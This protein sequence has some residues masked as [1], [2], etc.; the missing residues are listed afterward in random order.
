MQ[1]LHLFNDDWKFHFGDI[2]TVRNRWAWAKSGSFNQGPESIAFDDLKWREVRL[3][4][5][6]VFETTPYAYSE[7]E[8]DEDN[9]IPEMEDVGNIHTTA[10]SFDKNVGWYRKHFFIPK[11]STP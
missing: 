6:F 2:V 9:A 4:H 1:E 10:G 5:D 8:F 3:P 7:K 11:I